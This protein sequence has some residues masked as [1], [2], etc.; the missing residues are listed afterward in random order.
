MSSRSSKGRASSSEPFAICSTPSIHQLKKKLRGSSTPWE[1]RRCSLVFPSRL[2]A[3]VRDGDVRDVMLSRDCDTVLFR[4][5]QG[6]NVSVDFRNLEDFENL[7]DGLG[8]REDVLKE[9]E[10]QESRG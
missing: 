10:K 1:E 3:A 9:R 5:K 8:P 4:L 2:E 7:Y 6:K